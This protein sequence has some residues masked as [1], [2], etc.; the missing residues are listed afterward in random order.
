MPAPPI[1]SV[2][3]V[4][5]RDG[6]F[7]FVEENVKSRLVINQPAGRLEAGESLV[8]ATVREA[9]EETGWTIEP[10]GLVGI[11]RWTSEREDKAYVRVCFHGCALRHDT[12]RPLDQG[13]ER[14]LWLNHATL[15]QRTQELRSPLV[16][17]CVNDYLAGRRFPLDLL[18]DIAQA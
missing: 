11:Y 2:A 9:L 5:E 17:R 6:T 1:I 7:L 13:I 15:L 8:N 12:Q 3:T 10:L 14:V 4:V 16:L 18:V